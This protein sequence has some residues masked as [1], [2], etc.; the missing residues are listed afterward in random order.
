MSTKDWILLITPILGNGI[1]VFLLQKQFEKRQLAMNE[2]YT[3]VSAMRNKIDKALETFVK[4]LQSA[5][6][7]TLQIML[8]NQYVQD[9]SD[10]FY[11]Y[12][13]N[14]GLMK[15]L[16]KYMDK[17]LEIHKDVQQKTSKSD[18]KQGDKNLRDIESD[19]RE[20]YELLQKMQSD[21]INYKI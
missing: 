21:C 2:K 10:V 20:I 9:Y 11:Y 6:N 1:I 13:Q 17:M 16:K 7:E 4:M 8:V 14:E 15:P 19:F 18:E 3:Y 5:G 12:Q